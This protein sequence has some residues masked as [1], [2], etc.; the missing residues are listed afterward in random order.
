MDKVRYYDHYCATC[1]KLAD[2]HDVRISIAG[3]FIG[4]DSEGIYPFM[5]SD[6]VVKDTDLLA[7]R[8]FACVKAVADLCAPA[9]VRKRRMAEDEDADLPQED[10]LSLEQ[11]NEAAE[12]E[13]LIREYLDYLP[14]DSG[15]IGMIRIST[16]GHVTLDLDSPTSRGFRLYVCLKMIDRKLREAMASNNMLLTYLLSFRYSE[17]QSAPFRIDLRKCFDPQNIDALV[18]RMRPL[19]AADVLRY[20]CTAIF[21]LCDMISPF[22][23]LV[24]DLEHYRDCGFSVTVENGIPIIATFGQLSMEILR[25]VCPNCGAHLHSQAC[26]FP[27]KIISFVGMP[28]CGKSTIITGIFDL[29]SSS[30][31]FFASG[32]SS[33]KDPFYAYFKAAKTAMNEKRAI[34]KT[35]VGFYPYCALA[36]EN[37]G[38]RYLYYFVDVPG[39]HFL[40]KHSQDDA[41]QGY[42]EINMNRLSVMEHSDVICICIAAEQ[43]ADVTARQDVD[44]SS[45]ASAAPEDLDSFTIR[46]QQFYENVLHA[47]AP[48]IVFAVTK[49]DALPILDD[50]FDVLTTPDNEQIEKWKHSK[51][52]DLITRTEIGDFYD[53]L[54]E[55]NELLFPGT[56][57][58]DMAKLHLQQSIARRMLR[59]APNTSLIDRVANAVGLDGWEDVPVFFT[60]PLAFYAVSNV[61]TMPLSQKKAAYL[62]W[63]EERG[64]SLSDEACDILAKA[65]HS[66]FS[67]APMKEAQDQ[68]H[69]ELLEVQR[70]LHLARSD[71]DRILRK[72]Y[73]NAHKSTHPYGVA[74]FL[75]YI[76]AMTA[77][78]HYGFDRDALVLGMDH[79]HADA[80]A[81]YSPDMAAKEARIAERLEMLQARLESLREEQDQLQAQQSEQKKDII[82]FSMR[83]IKDFFGRSKAKEG[84]ES[85]LDA[86]NCMIEDTLAELRVLEG[87]AAGM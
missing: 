19:F 34:E 4:E 38:K 49:A 71:A 56:S 15:E 22:E 24:L 61:W 48:P 47:Q 11:L 57:I 10:V 2:P 30:D 18:Q 28:A 50:D 3:Y 65:D 67:D 85:R 25:R 32:S 27:Q 23:K 8:S 84:P 77:L 44:A 29:L 1:G 64:I 7:V 62:S 58:V 66:M 33:Y 43:L 52:D 78:Y 45:L 13:P 69:S 79:D 72:A 60:S 87:G 83:S 70:S 46:M 39:E 26:L 6:T 9:R 81:H 86:V 35:S 75:A 5:N 68:I 21:E 82:A 41:R 76:M 63:A 55:D 53:S 80:L 31:P 40:D 74:Q 14:T 12:K 42:Y 16:P 54:I 17:D 73:Q 59:A 36:L 51:K 37:E 20:H